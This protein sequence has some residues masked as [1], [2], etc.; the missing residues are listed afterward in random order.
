MHIKENAHK[1]WLLYAIC[2]FIAAMLYFSIKS[3]YFGFSGH[4]EAFYIAIPYRFV[5]GDRPFIDEYNLAQIAGLILVPAVK[6]FLGIEKST[7]GIIIFARYLYFFVSLLLATLIYFI[8]KRITS[9]SA[10]LLLAL[11]CIIFAPFNLH[12]M[13][14]NSLA[15]LLLTTGCFLGFLAIAVFQQ[16]FKDEDFSKFDKVNFLLLCTGG[17]LGL[18]SICYPTLSLFCAAYLAAILFFMPG[19]KTFWYY[20]LGVS[21]SIFWF[22]LMA[23]HVGW[24]QL[25]IDLQYIQSFGIEGGGFT[26]LI[27]V[28]GGIWLNIPHKHIMAILLLAMILLKNHKIVQSLIKLALL[29][30]ITIPVLKVPSWA[31]AAYFLINLTVLSPFLYWNIRNLPYVKTLFFAIVL[32]SLFAGVVTGWSSGEGMINSVLGLFPASLV[33]V[34][35]LMLH[36]SNGPSSEDILTADFLLIIPIIVAL[37]LQYFNYSFTYEDAPSS[38]LNTKILSGPFAGIYT[39]QETQNFSN[40]LESDIAQLSEANQRILFFDDFPAGYLFT[41]MKPASNSVWLFSKELFSGVDRNA[42]LNYYRS[43]KIWPGLIVKI[44]NVPSATFTVPQLLYSENQDDPLNGLLQSYKVILT[45]PDYVIYR[46]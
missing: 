2:F 20:S 3:L 30:I 43:E 5:L 8:F 6:L 7:L 1:K 36:D 31:G 28:I 39:L 11:P 35:F 24:K 19:V 10:A 44:L 9:K 16:H 32:P 38:Q 12:A 41:N 22:L 21:V 17:S 26:K 14:Y 37:T 27:H 13:S 45:R 33:T 15:M 23:I 34:Y 46:A 29:A 18:M 40:Q 42:T 4:D 25:S